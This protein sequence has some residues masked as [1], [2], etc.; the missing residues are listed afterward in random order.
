[1]NR[2]ILNSKQVKR[3]CIDAIMEIKGEDRMEVIIK[4]HK[5]AKTDEQRNFW[6]FLLS[7]FG[8]EV[9]YT[10]GEMKTI[11]KKAVTG[12][13]QLCVGSVEVEVIPS[14][15]KADK[16]LYGAYIETTYRLAAEVGVALPALRCN[17]E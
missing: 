5:K 8:E 7:V 9:G 10:L 3:N 15:E 12:S 13:E 14:S 16:E 6:H 17:G 4:K 2:F 11:V 1:V